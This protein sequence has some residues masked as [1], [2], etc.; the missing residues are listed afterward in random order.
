MLAGFAA[1]ISAFITGLLAILW[2]NEKSALVYISTAA[3]ALLIFY[4]AGEFMFPH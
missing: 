4:L 1:G 2:Q 3:G